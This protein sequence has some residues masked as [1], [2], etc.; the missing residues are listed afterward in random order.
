MVEAVKLD[1][2]THERLT[3]YAKGGE[4]LDMVINRV[5]DELEEYKKGVRNKRRILTL[6]TEGEGNLN[7]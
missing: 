5:L 3:T 4:T 1:R 7:Y 2:N 6:H